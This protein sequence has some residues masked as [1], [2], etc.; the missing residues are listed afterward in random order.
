MILYMSPPN[1]RRLLSTISAKWQNT[2]LVTLQK[3]VAKAS[4]RTMVEE[5]FQNS[6]LE[7]CSN[8]QHGAV[9]ETR[10]DQ[11]SKLEGGGDRGGFS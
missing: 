5:L 9:T 2:K 11:Q 6:E 3:Q 10:V 8:K 7:G 4:L 1:A